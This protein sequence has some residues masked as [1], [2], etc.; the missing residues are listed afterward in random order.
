MTDTT[1][2]S[3]DHPALPGHFPG[4]PIVPGAVLLQCVI[5]AAARA[6]PGRPVGG[7]KR[8]K[9]LA[10]LAPEQ[11]FTIAFDAPGASG[12]RFRV[13]FADSADGAT[14]ADGNLMFRPGD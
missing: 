11:A 7:V 4:R 12:L 14:I 2:I 9:F 5:E 6:A 3:A 13:L 8:V 10:M 1:R